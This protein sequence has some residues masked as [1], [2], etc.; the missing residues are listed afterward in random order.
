MN[1]AEFWRIFGINKRRPPECVL[2][3]ASQDAGLW[4]IALAIQA[5]ADGGFEDQDPE[6]WQKASA[7]LNALPL[8]D[9]L[10][11]LGQ[12][13]RNKT[14]TNPDSGQFKIDL[15]PFDLIIRVQKR[16]A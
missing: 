6:V 5:G 8:L 7:N 4:A 1:L 9:G 15:S 11:V 3:F 13:V 16:A 14:T 2:D 10:E 12:L